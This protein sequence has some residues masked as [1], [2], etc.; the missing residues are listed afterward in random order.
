MNSLLKIEKWLYI[1]LNISLPL[2][3]RYYKEYVKRMQ[4]ELDVQAKSRLLIDS[5]GE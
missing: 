5:L 3:K 4:E 1:H 2:W